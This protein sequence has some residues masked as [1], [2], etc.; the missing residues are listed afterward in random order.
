MV[1]QHPD[2]GGRLVKARP[3]PGSKAWIKRRDPLRIHRPSTV[4]G[5]LLDMDE[6]APVLM[7]ELRAVAVAGI[8]D[9]I[10]SSSSMAEA[11]RT[12]GISRSSLYRYVEQFPE[13]R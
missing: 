13:L 6:R 3:V 12:L 9:A 5:E 7:L 4:L 10:E 2:E 8:R 11:A 1:H